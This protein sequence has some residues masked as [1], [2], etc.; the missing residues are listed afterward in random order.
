MTPTPQSNADATLT[1]PLRRED[2]RLD[3]TRPAAELERQVRAYD[4]WP[5]SFVDLDAGRLIVH[6]ATAE[7]GAA[8]EPGVIDVL[9][10]GTP[11]G[12]A[13]RRE[14]DALGRLHPGPPRD[15]R[16]ARGRPAVKALTPLTPARRSPSSAG[17]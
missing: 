14:T 12:A 16:G 13:R 6:A 17:P 9:G 3:P 2:G 11:R 1:R 4:P 5:G 7:P 10:L 15:R 8:T